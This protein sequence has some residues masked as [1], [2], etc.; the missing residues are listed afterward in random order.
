MENMDYQ[1]L[2]ACSIYAETMFSEHF[3]A[4]PSQ[5]KN[6]EIHINPSPTHQCN[7]C[8]EAV[9]DRYEFKLSD[10]CYVVG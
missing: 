10:G 6:M 3:S 8:K 1:I 2:Q 4:R 7:E 5:Q 9:R